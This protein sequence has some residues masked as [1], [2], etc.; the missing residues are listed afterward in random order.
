MGV[1]REGRLGRA[2]K[3]GHFLPSKEDV[4]QGGSLSMIVYGIGFLPLI[5]ELW[6]AHPRVTQPWYADD[7]GAGGGIQAHTGQ[8]S[9]HSGE[10]P[11]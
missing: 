3:S 2:R 8:I 5:R 7:T 4:T 11:A 6:E 10:G 9:G 1:R